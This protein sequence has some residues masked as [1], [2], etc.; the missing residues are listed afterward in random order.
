LASGGDYQRRASRTSSASTNR[1]R[2]QGPLTDFEEDEVLKL[3]EE[4]YYEDNF[5]STPHELAKFPSNFDQ[6]RNGL[7]IQNSKQTFQK[8][9]KNFIIIWHKIIEN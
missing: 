1:G 3:L 8:N 2:L 6:V 4:V 5:D 7:H 9:P